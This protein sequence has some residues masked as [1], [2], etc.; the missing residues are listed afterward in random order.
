ME[1]IKESMKKAQCII[2]RILPPL[3]SP[4]NEQKPLISP[5]ILFQL[6]LSCSVCVPYF[7]MLTGSLIYISP[8]HTL[9]FS[10]P[11]C[12]Q[13]RQTAPEAFG[14]VSV[15]VCM[16]ASVNPFCQ[17]FGS[18]FSKQ[19]PSMIPVPLVLVRGVGRKGLWDSCC[20]SAQSRPLRPWGPGLGF[21]AR[22]GSVW[23]LWLTLQSPLPGTPQCKPAFPFTPRKRGKKT[24]TH[25][26][27]N[28]PLSVFPQLCISDVLPFPRSIKLFHNNFK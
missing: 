18:A 14:F 2:L 10:F 3:G 23:Q 15:R 11:P 22:R 21:A 13:A 8:P 16:H 19:T 1:T 12:P 25:I 7:Q 26:F 28:L 17:V 5:I 20:S 6:S 4:G 9:S 24:I 27:S